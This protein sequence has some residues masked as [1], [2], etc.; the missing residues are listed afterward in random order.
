MG[1][2]LVHTLCLLATCTARRQRTLDDGHRQSD[3]RTESCSAPG[4]KEQTCWDD[5]APT[6]YTGGNENAAK[7][8]PFCK[9]TPC[10]G[11][12]GNTEDECAGCPKSYL[13]HA[14]AAGFGVGSHT[15]T[16]GSPPP[17]PMGGRPRV[18]SPSGRRDTSPR[19]RRDY[20]AILAIERTASEREIRRAY[21]ERSRYFADTTIHRDAQKA[22]RNRKLVERAYEVLSQPSLRSRYD[23]GEDVDDT[24]HLLGG[25]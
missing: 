19:K 14:G 20:Y 25:A 16:L 1:R 3:A 2:L 9:E 22:E 18:S 8:L 15:R 6:I 10:L 13:C 5:G 7:C 17:P 21:R 23:R 11:L 12:N 24:G 4:A